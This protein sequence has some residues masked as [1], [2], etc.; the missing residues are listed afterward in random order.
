MSA[1]PI[2]IIGAGIGGLTLGRALLKQGIPAVLYER[3]PST[4]R[5]SY[6]VT[7]HAASYRH[8]L[9]VLDIDESTFRRA[10]AVDGP[11]GG[12]G[13]INHKSII[14][15]GDITSSSFRAHRE[16]LERLLRE[17]LDI[18]WKHEVDEIQQSPSGMVL[19]LQTGEK[20]NSNYIVGV[21]GPHSSVRNSMSPNT[22]LRILPFV[23]FNGKRRVTRAIFDSVYAPY[24]QS[25]N[26]IEM[27]R[28][29]VVLQVQVSEQQEDLVS[30][31][32]VY[33]R[34]ARGPTD[35]LHKPNRPLS[36]ATNIP[37][38]FFEEINT[39]KD[40]QQPFK[41]VFDADKLRQENVLHWL[42]R[43]VRVS[44]QELVQFAKKGVFFIGDAVH[45]E[46]II[47][48]G[49]ANGAIKDGVELANCLTN[50]GLEALTRFYDARYPA[51]ESGV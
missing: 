49:G 34:P 5:Y 11:V 21:D 42:M 3:K 40:L 28:D 33:S 13:E 51:W 47:G 26:I 44:V 38:E 36:G 17:G 24:M 39:L 10:V 1:Q 14:H 41:E 8:L 16:R 12:T 45:A 50:P 46:P 31:A 32:W 9:D 48:G 30:V 20:I 18:R 19:C 23:A 4:S 2:S 29:S 22:S 43:T 37:E 7:L 15:T 25:S 6:G 35:A 27:K